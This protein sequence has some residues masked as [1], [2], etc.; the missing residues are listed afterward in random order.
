MNLSYRSWTSGVRLVGIAG[1]AWLVADV[2]VAQPA[3]T[4]D[5]AD[6]FELTVA[7]IM[8]GPDLVGTSPSRLR[9]SPD[10]QELYFEWKRPDEE[11]KGLYRV[12]RD[13]NGLRRLSDEE[14]RRIEALGRADYS[15]DRRYAAYSDE[16]K[17]YL[18]DVRTGRELLLVSVPGSI[19]S[20]QIAPDGRAVYFVQQDNLFR[21]D[22]GGG[23]TQLTD[24]RHGSEPRDEEPDEQAEFLEQEQD[25]LLRV[26]EADSIRRGRDW[27]PPPDTAQVDTPQVFYVGE[28]E[29]IGGFW[30]APDGSRMAFSLTDETQDARLAWVPDYV[31]EGGYTEQA[32]RKRTFVGDDQDSSKVGIMDLT[33]GAVSWIDH[34]QGDRQVNL[35]FRGWSDD[36]RRLLAVGISFDYHD[37]WVLAVDG[38]TS[39]AKTIDHLH[40]D[41]WIGG[42]E[43]SGA[44]WLPGGDHVWF[45]SEASGYSHVYTA[46]VGGGEPSPLTTGPWEV[47][48]VELSPDEREFYLVTSEPGPHER[49]FYRMDLDGKNR[50][51]ITVAGTLHGAD[52][53]NSVAVAPDG[54]RLAVLYSSSDHPAELYV[55]DSSE[56]AGAKKVTESTTADFRARD[57]MEP[58]V[59]YFTARDEVDI[60]ARL[61]RPA[62]P[63]GAAVI[64]V[65][66]A[67]YLQNVH[68]WWSSYYREYMFHNLL[69][70]RGYT[71]LDID[72]RGSAGYGRDWRTAI[73]KDMGAVDLSDQVDGARF[74][75]EDMGIDPRRIGIYGGSYGGFITLMAMFTEP[76]VFAAGAA[77]RP[78]TDWAYYNHWYTSRILGLPH[79]DAE[80]YRRSSPIYHA[81]GLSGALLIAHGM[82]DQNVHFQ[83]SVRL[84]ERLLELG[85]ENWEIAI[86]PKEDHGFVHDWAWTDEY[87]RILKLFEENLNQ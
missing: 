30:V 13:G 9:W 74:L 34:G 16:G 32:P 28:E 1:V 73:R 26:F 19:S 24:I 85:K 10:G 80:A 83:D 21:F 72:Y 22:V 46:A 27:P 87:R 84:A 75:V 78:V 11:K 60:P 56:G 36:S 43:W 35:M 6:D 41:A 3:A 39:E 81:D 14:G 71:V 62:R 68:R 58:E 17:L 64:F 42:P 69:A 15:E 25:R 20:V 67:G 5:V 51:R 44:G 66:G 57:W 61:Y 38:A 65:H 12:G 18:L 82:I 8:R 45:I 23:L 47:V 79:D 63:N 40:D 53:G 55:Q 54:R 86:Y 76:G 29:R 49:A 50:R 33:S 31:T 37:R 77:L 4:V 48:D 70:E 59:V 2:A 52:D 7:N